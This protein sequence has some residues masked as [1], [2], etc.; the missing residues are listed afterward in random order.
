MTESVNIPKWFTLIASGVMALAIPWAG[1]VTMTLAT[2]S[3]RMEN[4][5]TFRLQLE[6]MENKFS[7]HITDPTIHNFM[8]SDI[9]TNTRI[10]ESLQQR[11][12][13]LENA[14]D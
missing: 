9:E 10:L 12:E 14:Q 5:A 8:R 6:K 1:W 2:I 4:Q 3:V 7:A 11:I 13:R